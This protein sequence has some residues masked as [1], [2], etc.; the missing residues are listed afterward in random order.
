MRIERALGIARGAGGVAQPCGGVL[1]E[2]GEIKLIMRVSKQGL[3][4]IDL[5]LGLRLGRFARHG[6]PAFDR[7]AMLGHRI[8]QRRE[9]HVKEDVLGLGVINDPGELF[10][11]ETR[12]GGVYDCANAGHGVIELHMPVGVPGDGGDPVARF[13]LQRSCQDIGELLGPLIA[14][15]IAIAVN[16]ARIG[17]ARHDFALAMIE[18]CMV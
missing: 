11:A 10:G 3:V 6:D 7:L 15:G 16:F 18:S 12:I 2:L 9:G 4:N 8:D 1:I 17:Q 5:G 14:I 13:Y